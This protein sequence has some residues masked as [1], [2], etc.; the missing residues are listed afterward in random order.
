MKWELVIEKGEESDATETLKT[1]IEDVI[2]SSKGCPK[3][4]SMSQINLSVKTEF[5][6]KLHGGIWG[7]I[8]ADAVRVPAEFTSREERD[9]DPVK[10]IRAY[11]T[12]H[13]P[14]GSWSDDTS[15]ILCLM[16]NIAE[17]YSIDNL[18]KLFI[19]KNF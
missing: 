15:L 14:Y 11:G 4:H 13:Q 2:F 10:E 16:Q 1:K 19:W 3:F 6:Q 7:F 9:K 8:L 12:Y 17:G 18:A 5:E